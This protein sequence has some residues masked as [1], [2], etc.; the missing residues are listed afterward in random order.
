M[1][2]CKV[3]FANSGKIIVYGGTEYKII[4]S[5]IDLNDEPF[6]K[7]TP[8]NPELQK[9]MIDELRK[10]GNFTV[11]IGPPRLIVLGDDEY[12]YYL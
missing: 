5:G 2:N 12:P 3:L 10:T 4:E 11:R 7:I 1:N 9:R 6:A 8:E